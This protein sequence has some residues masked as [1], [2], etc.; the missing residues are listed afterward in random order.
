M[1]YDGG[2]WHY[3][4]VLGI[5][6]RVT[7]TVEIRNQATPPVGEQSP[8]LDPVCTISAVAHVPD[9]L[10]CD[11]LTAPVKASVSPLPHKVGA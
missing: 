8:S 11:S 1:T 9:E 7:S 5:P 4:P 3:G 6:V 10:E 2:Q